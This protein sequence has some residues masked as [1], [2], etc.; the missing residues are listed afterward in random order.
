MQSERR[1]LQPH[2]HSIA[3]HD[4]ALARLNKNTFLPLPIGGKKWSMPPR[5]E[6]LPTY[7][8]RAILQ[9]LRTG[10][11]VAARNLDATGKSQT[12]PRLVAKGWIERGYSR[13]YYR[14]TPKGQA[15]LRAQIP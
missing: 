15:A 1:L 13:G 14:I 5:A 10:V 2:V 9:K 7:P 4:T 11:E 3:K 12:I 8:E 6:H